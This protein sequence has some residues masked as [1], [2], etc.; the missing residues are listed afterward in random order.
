MAF[1]FQRKVSEE[2]KIS[3][4][5]LFLLY[6]ISEQQKASKMFLQEAVVPV[7]VVVFDHGEWKQMKQKTGFT[8]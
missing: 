6:S 1:T 3:G 5:I 7:Y 8:W 4:T 2:K